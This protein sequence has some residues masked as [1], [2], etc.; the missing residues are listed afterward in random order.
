LRFRWD[1][2]NNGWNQWV[3]NYTPQRQK[4][5]LRSLGFD[6]IGWQML[7]LLTVLVS[8]AIMLVIAIPLL[9]NRGRRDPIER[10]YESLCKR[11]AR[12]GL[13][14]HLHEGPRTYAGRL[15]AA[16]SLSVDSKNAIKQFLALLE[17]AR[18]AA[19]D[20]SMRASLLSQLKNLLNRIQ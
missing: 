16:S 6:N 17:K 20:Q 15:L 1:A 9:L 2:V 14:P 11:M 4:S 18:Y 8:T 5:L 19:P 12:R 3:L 13:P 7:V 10:V